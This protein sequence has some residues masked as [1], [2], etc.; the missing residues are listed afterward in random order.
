[1]AVEAG[2]VSLRGTVPDESA[3]AELVNV[4]AAVG[5]VGAVDDH[6]EVEGTST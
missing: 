6:L 3:R 5:G 1:V 4:A 2:R